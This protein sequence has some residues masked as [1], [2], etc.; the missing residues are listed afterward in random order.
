MATFGKK[1]N[2]KFYYLVR[3]INWQL[4]RLNGLENILFH[5]VVV[6]NLPNRGCLSTNLTEIIYEFV[7]FY[8][9][10]IE[11]VLL[12]HLR[13]CHVTLA[14]YEVSAAGKGQ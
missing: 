3:P 10:L 1:L 8:L 11:N 9:N 4:F 5:N 7:E 2:I 12:V 13:E 14:A 6:L